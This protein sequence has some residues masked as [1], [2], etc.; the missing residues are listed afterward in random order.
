MG[1]IL[2]WGRCHFQKL[3]AVRCID[4]IENEIDF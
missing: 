1:L 3:I 4:F 2:L